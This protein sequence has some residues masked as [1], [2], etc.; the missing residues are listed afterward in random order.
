[1][2]QWLQWWAS[3]LWVLDPLSWWAQRKDETP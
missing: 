1:M 3:R 2:R